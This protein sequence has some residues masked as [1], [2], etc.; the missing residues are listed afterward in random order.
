MLSPADLSRCVS[1]RL[2]QDETA[3]RNAFGAPSAQRVRWCVVDDVFPESVPEQAY[4]ELPPLGAMLR[5]E[6]LKE[7]KYVT[8]NIDTLKPML[9]SL[10]LAFNRQDIADVVARIMGKPNLEVD[11]QLYNG[12]ITMMT[13]KDFMRPHLDN[14]HD[15]ARQRRREVVLLYYFSPYWEPEFGGDLAAWDDERRRGPTPIAFKPNRLVI[16]ETTDRSWHS[17]SPI[18]GPLPRVNV[19]SYFYAPRTETHPVRLTHFAAWPNEPVLHAAFSAEF[20]MRSL[21]ARLGAARFRKNQHVYASGGAAEDT[22]ERRS[23]EALRGAP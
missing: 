6:D 11:T 3:L 9:Q 13:P 7:R 17:V 1:Q 16:M 2:T 18:V 20:Q 19:I 12:G 23:L 22:A 15:Y 21:A 5:R 10:V 14:S 8:A 4:R